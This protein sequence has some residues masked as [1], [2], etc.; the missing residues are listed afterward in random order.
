MHRLILIWVSVLIALLESVPLWAGTVGRSDFDG[1]GI[2]GFSDFLLFVGFIG[3]RRGDGRYNGRYDLDANGAI[4]IDD[5]DIFV[6]DFGR[7]VSVE[8]ICDRSPKVC[9]AILATLPGVDHCALVRADHL[10]SIRSMVLGFQDI[11]VLWEADLAGMSSLRKL[12]L[13]H[14]YL[15]ALPF[16][17]LPASLMNYG[18]TITPF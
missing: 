13:S 7:S 8:G 6:N 16:E 18:L 12:Y 14:N 4:V 2:V 5:F 11:T 15:S 10:S 17:T 1:D 9:S 3:T